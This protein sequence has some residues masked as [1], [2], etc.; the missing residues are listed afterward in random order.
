MITQEEKTN[1]RIQ[2]D[3]ML[4]ET[5]YQ[6]ELYRK[7]HP[8]HRCDKEWYDAG[9]GRWFCKHLIKARRN[10]TELRKKWIENLFDSPFLKHSE[11]I[12]KIA[13]SIYTGT[14]HN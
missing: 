8:N 11:F 3:F 7:K 9:N 1:W 10:N 14:N 6:D 13:N 4:L 5:E 12:R 2:T